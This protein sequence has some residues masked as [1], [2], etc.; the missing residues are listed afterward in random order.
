MSDPGDRCAGASGVGLT[1]EVAT[2]EP[3]VF[4]IVVG[5]AGAVVAALSWYAVGRLVDSKETS[6]KEYRDLFAKSRT[7]KLPEPFQ[8]KELQ[9]GVRTENTQKSLFPDKHLPVVFIIAWTIL[10]ISELLA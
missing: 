7:L 9:W 8:D 6:W 5:A 4:R 1:S 3:K 10:V 2:H